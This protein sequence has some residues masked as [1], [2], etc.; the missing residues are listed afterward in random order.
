MDSNSKKAKKS[1]YNKRHREKNLDKIQ[2]QEKER[3]S[4]WRM[5]LKHRDEEAYEEQ[6]RK[7]RERKRLKKQSNTESLPSTSQY[8]TPAPIPTP[9][10]VPTPESAFKHRATKARSFVRAEKALPDTPRR[11]SEVVVGLAKKL[12]IDMGD[13]PKKKPGRTKVELGVDQK[14]WLVSYI[15]FLLFDLSIVFGHILAFHYIQ[16]VTPF[17]YYAVI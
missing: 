9:K 15:Y 17:N 8:T 1:E 10:S 6:K 5:Q 13:A 16:K 4:L 14:Q 7:D 11:R 2:A 3:K 12:R